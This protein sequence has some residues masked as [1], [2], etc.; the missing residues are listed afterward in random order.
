MLSCLSW[1][2]KTRPCLISSSPQT[3]QT[4]YSHTSS[5][6]IKPNTKTPLTSQA[7]LKSNFKK[8][9]QKTQKLQSWVTCTS[10]ISLIWVRHPPL[11]GKWSWLLWGVKSWQLS[12]GLTDKCHCPATKSRLFPATAHSPGHSPVFS[13]ESKE[14][15][16]LAQH[17]EKQGATK[18]YK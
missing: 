13:G 7:G 3:T 14:L 6:N 15:N 9:T 18:S 8:I 4:K 2:L 12:L 17:R 5:W 1:A 10:L 16:F 11:L